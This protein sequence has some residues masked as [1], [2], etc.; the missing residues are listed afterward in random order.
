MASWLVV[1]NA[2]AQRRR[3]AEVERGMFLVSG[4]LVSGLSHKVHKEHKE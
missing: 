3:G 1:F 4:F 2:E